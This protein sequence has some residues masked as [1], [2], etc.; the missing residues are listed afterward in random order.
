[1][2][3]D[4]DLNRLNNMV[5]GCAIEVHKVLGPGHVAQM[6]TYLKV[7]KL[8]LGL[9]LNFNVEVMQKGIRRVVNNF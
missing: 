6:L 1:M 2:K 8:R 5:I 7:N 9:L 4:D 3:S